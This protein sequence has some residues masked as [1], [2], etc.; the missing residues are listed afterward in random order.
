MDNKIR[1]LKGIFYVEFQDIDFVL[2]VIGFINQKLLGVFIIV[3]YFQ[4]EKNRV[5][6]FISILIKG[7]IGFMRLY[8]GFLYFNIIEE[9]FRGIFELFGKVIYINLLKIKFGKI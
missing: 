1:R 5:G 6:N 3:Q 8:V 9:M 7:N 2:L 4:V